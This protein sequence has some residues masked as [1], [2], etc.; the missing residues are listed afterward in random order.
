MVKVVISVIL[1]LFSFLPVYASDVL[2]I[3][4]SITLSSKE[5]LQRK[6]P[7]SV[8]D[9]KVGRQFSEVVTVIRK[10]NDRDLK[11]V[12]IALGTNGKINK[13]LL[14]TTIQYFTEKKTKVYFVNNNVPKPWE[15][16]NNNLLDEVSKFYGVT[17]IDWKRYVLSHTD[18]KLLANDKV[19][20]TNVGKE[21]FCSLIVSSIHH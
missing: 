3:G 1:I 10:Y 13:N 8:V 11:V 6:I 19:H 21:K 20:L 18:E 4:D 14:V 5:C 15:K 17:V 7:N 16:I 9:A 2:I 12:V